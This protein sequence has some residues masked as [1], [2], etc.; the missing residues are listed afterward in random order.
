MLFDSG[1]V[2]LVVEAIPTWL[3]VVLVVLSYLGSV[4]FIAPA[5]IAAYW[6][7]RDLVAPWLGG[8]VG[9][10]ALMS[11]TKSVH[12]LSRPT[13][14]PP[15]DATA[16]PS[17]YVPAYEHAAH[18]DTAS[19]PS[20]HAMV[21]TI[22]AGMVVYDLRV[23]TL[24]RRALVGAVF[25]GWVGFTRVGLGVHYPGDVIGGILYAL[26]FL[27][28][29]VAARTWIVDGRLFVHG[30]SFV[31]RRVGNSD[32]G[33]FESPSTGTPGIRGDGG[34]PRQARRYRATMVAFAIGL[35]LALV[36]LAVSGSRN[37]HIV[38]GAGLGGL[39]AWTVAPALADTIE[40]TVFERVLPIVAVFVVVSTWFVTEFG[41]GNTLF[42]VG[43]SALFLAMVVWVPWITGD[44]D[45]ATARRRLRSKS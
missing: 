41:I 23:G 15:V 26:A 43:W 35:S 29:Y 36:A 28:V 44:V 24:P 1:T 9:C 38:F 40:S 5:M 18:I 33:R 25:V 17:W 42:L 20:G 30:R 11:I 39:L 8:V 13:V 37:A 34:R 12:S 19:F 3:G 4:Y 22:V 2:E 14:D 31:D 21:A 45:P 6:Y 32:T 10:Y 16:F 27:V 7:R